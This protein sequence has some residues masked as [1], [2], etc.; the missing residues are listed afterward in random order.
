MNAMSHCVSIIIN[1]ILLFVVILFLL[2]FWG[3]N[4]VL[5]KER[6]LVLSPEGENFQYTIKGLKDDLED[7]VTF[8]EHSITDNMGEDIITKHIHDIN[9]K[10]LVFLGNKP[11]QAYSQYQKKYIGS[12]FPPSIALSALYLDR[13]VRDMKN[14]IG[15][16]FEI[17][18]V[19]SLVQLRSII[20]RPIKKVGVIYREW[21]SDFIKQNQ[22]Y[23]LQESI[24]L[25]GIKISDKPSMRHLNYQLKH[26]LRKDIDALW[27]VNDNGL[28]QARYLQNVWIPLLKRFDKPVLVGIKALTKTSLN[29]GTFS[30]EADHYALG[31]QG[32]EMISDIMDN[33]WRIADHKIEQPLSISNLLNIKLINKKKIPLDLDK[34][35]QIDQLIQ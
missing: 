28:L 14:I 4:N 24:Q 8:V 32:A 18:A 10:M 1:R 23:C 7:D 35:G 3:D 9:P 33:N 15:V 29:F 22:A 16:R 21:M 2:I 5:A 12:D 34:I 27:V 6:I 17:P 31:V 25:M 20:K 19:T 11:L 26:L 30:V 13:Q